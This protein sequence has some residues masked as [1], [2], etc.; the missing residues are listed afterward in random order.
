MLERK[1]GSVVLVERRRVVGIP[2][3]SDL[4]KCAASGRDLSRTLVRE[5]IKAPAVTPTPQ[6]P[7]EEAYS[8]M[9]RNNILHLPIISK[10]G[11]MFG[12]V[13]MMDLIS[14]GKSIL[15]Q[16]RYPQSLAL[17]EQTLIQIQIPLCIAGGVSLFLKS[18]AS[19]MSETHTMA[20][21]MS[22]EEN[23]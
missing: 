10:D 14:F 12:I 11:I 2:T 4:V 3:E 8:R 23:S 21:D 7:M 9:P 5:I 6:A 17:E 20:R 15:Q 18:L 22:D 1:I 16:L 13:A 19:R